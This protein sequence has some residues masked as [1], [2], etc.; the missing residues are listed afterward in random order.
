MVYI[1]IAVELLF[2]VPLSHKCAAY[3]SVLRLCLVIEFGFRRKMH[4]RIKLKPPY[5]KKQ[6]LRWTVQGFLE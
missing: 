1:S 3:G 4:G 5:K 6:E 2:C